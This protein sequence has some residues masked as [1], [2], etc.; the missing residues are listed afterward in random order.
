MLVFEPQIPLGLWWA[1]A[2]LALAA[3][4]WYA[5]ARDSGL[6]L[7]RR[8]LVLVL[9][10]LVL[11]APLLLLLNPTWIEPI[12]PPAGKPLITVLVDATQSMQVD[13]VDG[14]TRW[15]AALEM[16]EEIKAA[17]SQEFDVNII[18]F[19]KVMKAVDEGTQ[20]RTRRT[21]AIQI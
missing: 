17:A 14:E 5:L 6:G 3:W 10:A 19:G 18:R 7:L 20:S 1:M 12:I 8:S 11:I 4:A 2:V 13:D 9:M 21:A 15:Q 16:A